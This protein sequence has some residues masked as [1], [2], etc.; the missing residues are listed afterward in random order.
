M[1]G[2]RAGRTIGDLDMESVPKLCAFDG[3]TD[4]SVL[5]SQ[6]NREVT[7]HRLAPHDIGV[8]RREQISMKITRH[9]AS[10]LMVRQ[11]DGIVSVP[12]AKRT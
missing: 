8:T 1:R 4:I 11:A 2:N 5:G 3:L 7:H 6:L 12:V 9:V 10:C